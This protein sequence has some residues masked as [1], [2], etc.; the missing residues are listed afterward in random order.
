MKQYAFL[1]V[2]PFCAP[3]TELCGGLDK[4][5]LS[6]VQVDRGRLSM[7]ADAFF[8]RMPEPAELRTLEGRIEGIYGLK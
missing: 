3:V 5:T 2:F 1:E 8:P 6:A 7:L 4:A